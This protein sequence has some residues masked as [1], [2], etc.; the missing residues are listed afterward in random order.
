MP[1]SQRRAAGGIIG[2]MTKRIRLPHPPEHRSLN[3]AARAAGID[4]AT[5]AGRVHRGWTPE[6]AVSTPPISP[7]RPVKVGDRVFAS[8]AEA[9]AAAGLVESTIRARMARGISRADALAM[10]K[11]PSGRPP[12]AIREAALAAGLHPSVVW[13][14]LRIGWSLPR[15]LSVAP[16]RYR[17]RRQAAA[18]TEGR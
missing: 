4:G 16:K 13:G 7:E 8:R 14:R 1:R 15:A 17:T 9:L 5:A 18:I 11:R 2:A 12:G 3:A 6:H 10:G